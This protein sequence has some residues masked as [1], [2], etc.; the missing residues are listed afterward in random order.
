MPSSPA[1]TLQKRCG[2]LGRSELK[3]FS[4]QWSLVGKKVECHVENEQKAFDIWFHNP[5][6]S[7]G[8]QQRE[9][10]SIPREFVHTETETQEESQLVCPITAPFSRI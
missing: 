2:V 1:E 9:G 5:C 6:S 4:M 3:I 10:V 7:P 8:E